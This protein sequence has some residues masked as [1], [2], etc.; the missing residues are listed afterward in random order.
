MNRAQQTVICLGVLVLGAF[1][2]CPPYKWERTTYFLNS[3]SGVPHQ[4]MI[5][6]EN[7]GHVWIWSPPRGWNEQRTYRERI[8]H[9]AAVDWPRLGVYVGLTAIISLF[10][11]FAVLRQRRALK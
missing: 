4:A 10:L 5:Q 9:V 3:E 8:S 11:A 6:T 7:I 2:L 1:C